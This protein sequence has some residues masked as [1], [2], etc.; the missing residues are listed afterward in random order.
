[1]TLEPDADIEDCIIMDY[2]VIGRGSRLRR[3]IVDRYNLIPPNAEI[4][5][6]RSADE[7]RYHV[8]ASGIVVLP[9]GKRGFA[10]IY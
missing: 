10:P 6:E 9:K 2:T 7:Q 1:V 3:T 8:S 4:G 5:Y